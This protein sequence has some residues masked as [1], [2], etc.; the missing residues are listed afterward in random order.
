MKTLDYYIGLP[1]S[2]RTEPVW[3]DDGSFYWL[4][5]VEELDG[6]MTDGATELE[7]FNN[8]N[9]AFDA[10][11]Q[12]SLEWGDEVPL[13]QKITQAGEPPTNPV[14]LQQMTGSI[15]EWIKGHNEVIIRQL[16]SAGIQEPGPSA[17]ELTALHLQV[18]EQDWS[19]EP[20]VSTV[21]VGE[22]A[23]MPLRIDA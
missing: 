17:T 21:G 9:D 2:R 6:C 11:V 7:A 13:P 4:A 19:D 1:Y 12:A 18:S 8:L 10:Y 15:Q 16:G 3:E 22:D 20:I 23:G 5:W 14:D